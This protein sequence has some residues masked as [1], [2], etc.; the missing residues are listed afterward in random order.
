MKHT[1]EDCTHH[2]E[3]HTQTQMIVVMLLTVC[4]HLVTLKPIV[5][6]R[7]GKLTTGFY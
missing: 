4:C 1:A 5:G 3:T 7:M 2:A 6:D